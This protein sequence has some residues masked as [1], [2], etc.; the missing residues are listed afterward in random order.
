MPELH[1]HPLLLHLPLPGYTHEHVADFDA[2]PRELR[3]EDLV[4]R[5]GQASEGLV[6]AGDC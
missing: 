6:Q 4:T 3:E 2:Q 1:L 5:E